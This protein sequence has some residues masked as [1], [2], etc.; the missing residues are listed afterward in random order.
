MKKP[1]THWN[2]LILAV[3]AALLAITAGY[4]DYK[5]SLVIGLLSVGAL[6][7]VYRKSRSLRQEAARTD[8]TMQ[9]PFPFAEQS[10]T[11]E[12]ISDEDEVEGVF[13]IVARDLRRLA[14]LTAQSASQISRT[15]HTIKTENDKVT[16]AMQEAAERLK[17]ATFGA[18][19][20]S[21]SL[22]SIRQSV[23]DTADQISI[24]PRSKTSA[25]SPFAKPE[26][27]LLM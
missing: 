16:A 7:Y 22:G 10:G 4:V 23:A 6:F 3:G 13:E 26:M 19:Q 12:R 1:P 9:Q 18:D 2:I 11:R 14:E 17:Q 21:E 27:T 20:A 5:L 15:A 25:S 8:W 24:A